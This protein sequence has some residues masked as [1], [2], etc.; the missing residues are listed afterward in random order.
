MRLSKTLSVFSWALLGALALSGCNGA[1]DGTDTDGTTDSYSLTLGYKTVVN[2]K[3]ADATTNLSFASDTSFCAV[4]TLKKGSSKL[5]GQLISFAATLGTVAPATKLTNADGVAEVIISNPALTAEAGTVTASYTPS[6]ADALTASRNYEFVGSGNGNTIETPKLS[7]SIL[8]SSALV[9]RF[10]VDESVQLQAILL[11]SESK[12]IEGAKVTFTAGSAALNPTSALT[13]T[14]GIAQV[15]YTPSATELGA[16]A[17]TVT[18]DYQGQSL[19]TSSLYEVLSKDAVNQEGTLKLGSF[20]GAVFTE[21]KLASTLTADANG[22]YKIS[23][24]G[25][26]GVSASL[27]L[28]ANDGTVTRVQTPS[29]ISFSSDC[30]TNNSA[31]LDTPVTTLSGNASST[32]Q[33]TSCSGNSERSDQIIATT[34]AGNQTLTANFPFTLQRQTLASLSFESAEPAQ[35]RIK[36]AGGTGSSESSLVSFKVTSANG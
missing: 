22:K 1:A 20:N 7:A 5:S 27:V 31:T 4:A 6:D 2:G 25:S 8:S 13:N 16:N 11:D 9:T 24:G 19:Q 17:L 23:A 3:C 36:G 10:K 15:P 12:G 28:E 32:F 26:F 18:V 21:G 35:I 30:T 29:S 14:Q 33:D 34:V